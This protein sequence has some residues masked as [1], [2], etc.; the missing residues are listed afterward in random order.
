MPEE[1]M[2]FSNDSFGQHYSS[3]ERFAIILMVGAGYMAGNS[4]QIVQRDF[5]RIEHIRIVFAEL[6]FAF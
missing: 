1:N 4:F 6:L 2:L 5:T 3:S